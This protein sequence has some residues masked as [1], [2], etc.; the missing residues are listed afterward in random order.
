VSWRQEPA[1][2]GRQLVL[3]WQERGGPEVAP[4]ERRSFGSRLIEDGIAYELG[5]EVNLEFL[6]PGV[7]CELRFPLE[8]SDGPPGNL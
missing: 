6:P 3:L 1:A 7:R 2:A 8:R 5:G 4:P